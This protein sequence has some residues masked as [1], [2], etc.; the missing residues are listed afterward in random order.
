MILDY[1]LSCLSNSIKKQNKLVNAD[2]K[3]LFN[4]L[5]ANKISLNEKKNLNGNLW[6]KQKKLEGELKIKCCK[7][8]YP[9]ESVKYLGVK[10][11]SI[12]LDSII[13]G[14]I[15]LMTFPLNW[16]EIMLSFS[17]WGNMLVLNIKIYIFCHF[18]LLL[19]LLLSCL[20]SEF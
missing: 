3:H 15:M 8:L 14:S 19:I 1:S 17:K 11:D 4:C 18:R 12:I 7:I 2:L 10:I 5:N 6:G 13:L 16:I 20:G 9:T